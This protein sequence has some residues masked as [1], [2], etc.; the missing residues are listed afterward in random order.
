MTISLST[1]LRRLGPSL[2]K[3]GLAACM[4]LAL[5]GCQGTLAMAPGSYVP[6]SHDDQALFAW[7]WPYEIGAQNW[8][9]VRRARSAVKSG[10]YA[11]GIERLERMA[12]EGL[13]PAYYEL[14]KMY[15]YGHGVSR[16]LR[17]AE[18]LY[19]QAIRVNSSI[20]DNASYNL[21]RL[22][23]SHPEL[24]EH[25]LL[26]YHLLRQALQGERG[27]ES[28]TWLASLLARGGEGV[29]ADPER[30]LSLY[31]Q[32]I[33]LDSADALLALAE[34]YH[35]GGFLP[36]DESASQRY[37]E[38]YREVLRE[39]S[40]DDD[41]E[42]MLELARLYGPRGMLGPNPEARLAWLQRAAEDGSADAMRRAGEMLLLQTSSRGFA[43]LERAA[44]RGSVPAMAEVGALY[45]GERGL[46]ADP[47][48]A[49]F[50]LERAVSQHSQPAAITLGEALLVGDVLEAEPA[51]GRALLEKAGR[52]GEVRAL[53]ILGRAFR[54]GHPGVPRR[55]RIA[56]DY[57]ERGHRLG[58]LGATVALGKA[59]L[60]GLS[61]PVGAVPARPE[62]GEA[63]LE[64]AVAR[65]DAGAMRMLA[66]AYLQ[67]GPLAYRPDRARSLLQR[68]VAQGDAAAMARLADAYLTGELGDG[69]VRPA[70]DLLEAAA[71]QGNGYAMVLLGRAYRQAPAD[72]TPDLEASE[73][74]LRRA[75]EAGHPSAPRALYNTLYA[76]GLEGDVAA[77]EEAAQ[78]GHAGAMEALGER[79]LAG[80]GVAPDPERAE[81][82]LVEATRSGRDGAALRLGRAY[83]SGEGLARDVTKALRYLAPLAERGNDA[84]ALALGRAYLH[85]EGVSQDMEAGRHYLTPLAD[86]GDAT[87]AR[88][89]GRAY[90]MGPE[91]FRRPSRAR[92]YL[93]QAV[94]ADD[95]PAQGTLGTALLRGDMGLVQDVERG[96]RLLSEAAESG[97]AGSLMVLGREYL[98]A[99]ILPYRPERGARY[100]LRAA[101]VGHDDARF[102][103]VKAY[104]RANGLAPHRANRR[105]ATLW[106]NGLIRH[107]DALALETLYEVLAEMPSPEAASVD[108]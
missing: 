26:A 85:G 11:D 79:Y 99:E 25:G 59:Y 63:L 55:P 94:A 76:Q 105:Q 20:R 38:R 41:T 66:E 10:D 4:V 53:V 86:A 96:Q 1:R 30:A 35:V 91:S 95:M 72:M 98:S 61:G 3:V 43:M 47:V 103:L 50:W 87:A 51:R 69:A 77:L 36:R 24:G 82:W 56:L 39:R 14:A 34:G 2:G 62:K 97:H 21:A 65:G 83:L 46:G 57:F 52:Q 16:H 45:L 7:H 19:R 84:A 64:T 54:D 106:L 93:E 44:H 73:R 18:A 101:R 29:P 107:D 5:E 81:R 70:I 108:G 6:V 42:A 17:R 92:R 37:L 13:P 71:E 15:H 49:R 74:W 58:D 100:L 104:L 32:A 33:A 22:Y 88:E 8:E 23:L 80:E 60:E 102:A 67:G 27:A 40:A 78:G 48:Q 68:A 89:L 75:V 9:R 31:Q 12:E 90:L 28:L